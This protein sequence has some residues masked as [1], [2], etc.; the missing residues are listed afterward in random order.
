[1]IQIAIVVNDL[2]KYLKRY[3]ELLAVKVSPISIL[4]PLSATGAQ[5]NGEP[6][7]VLA[8]LAYLEFKNVT[9]ELIEA[10]GGPSI[11]QDFL[12]RKGEGCTAYCV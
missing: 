1:M 9:L 7:T 10:F 4:P 12:D 2:E 8:R 5:H 3:A 6:M 11:W